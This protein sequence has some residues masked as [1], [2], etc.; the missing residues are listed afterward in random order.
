MQ[1]ISDVERTEPTNI[2][3]PPETQEASIVVYIQT[4]E[5]TENQPIESTGE[6]AT[7]DNIRYTDPLPSFQ[8]GNLLSIFSNSKHIH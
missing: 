7:F 6:Q 3:N 2:T 5:V 1:V 8:Q 4:Q